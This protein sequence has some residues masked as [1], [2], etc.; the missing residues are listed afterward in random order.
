MLAPMTHLDLR[1]DAGFIVPVEPPEALAEHALLVDRGRIV[2]LVPRSDAERDYTA[3]DH[4]VLPHHVLLPGLVNAHTHAAMSL[5]R[6][7]ADDVPLSRWLEDHIWPREAKFVAPD[8]AYDGTRLAA[9]E[10]LKGGITCC[11]DMYFFPDAGARAFLET[12]MRAMLGLVVLDFPTPYAADPDGY[13]Q[14][15]LAVRDACKHESRLSFAFAPHA[16]YTVGDAAFERIVTYAR[17]LDLP[18]ETHL[19]ETA[20]E[21]AQS[22]ERYGMT[23]L[24]RLHL[25]GA[26]GPGLIAIHGVHVTTEDIDLLATHGGHVVHCPASNM[27]LGSGIAPMT[28]LAAKGINIALGTD[29]AAS[30]NRLDLFGEMRLAALLAKA[31]TENAAALPARDVLHAATIGGA[32][33]LGLDRSIGSLVPG[34]EAD[35]VAVDFSGIGAVPCYDPISH[36][37][38]VLGRDA[39]TDVWV[40]GRRVVDNRALTTVDEGAIVGRARLWQ[41][42][43]Q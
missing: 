15:G 6:G 37:V 26:T 14:A 33:A 40:A 20:D 28:T 12:G 4:V 29:G 2:A 17:Q 38:H 9:A 11:N 10:M 36:L 8:F 19:A 42:K 1:I 30:N 25:L 35:I 3:R 27:K 23:P 24:A 5:F 16:P 21:V 39:V 31:A 34:K 43:L 41:E 13:L 32:R 22:R 18:I 7:I